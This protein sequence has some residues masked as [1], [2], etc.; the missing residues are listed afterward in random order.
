M[1]FNWD[2]ANLGHIARHNVSRFEAEQALQNNPIELDTEVIDGE[3]RF[4]EVGETNSGRI[5]VVVATVRDEAT[6]VVTAWEAPFATK[7]QY[8]E[9]RRRTW[10]L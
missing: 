10:R 7:R 6:R 1:Q 4:T 5:L 3:E 9:E 8:L 2:E